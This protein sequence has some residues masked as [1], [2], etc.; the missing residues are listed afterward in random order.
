MIMAKVVGP[1]FSEEAN[2]SLSGIEFRTGLYGPMVGARSAGPS[3]RTQRQR[4]VMV[5]SH[6]LYRLWNNMSESDR[7]YWSA[8]APE[9]L[10]GYQYFMQVNLRQLSLERAPILR[11][12]GAR[13]WPKNFKAT[14]VFQ[15]MPTNRIVVNWRL[16]LDFERLVLPW[17]CPVWTPRKSINRAKYIKWVSRPLASRSVTI[18]LPYEAPYYW[19]L[20]QGHDSRT[21]IRYNILEKLIKTS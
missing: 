12:L 16:I 20:V 5:R 2:G 6:I 18:Q 9:N 11:P 3:R 10:S 4:E 13:P 17:Y 14:V 19:L 1:L 21:G 15:P 8:S 7:L